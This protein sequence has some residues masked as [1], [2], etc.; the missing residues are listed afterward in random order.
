MI[1]YVGGEEGRG[2]GLLGHLITRAAIVPCFT[3]AVWAEVAAQAIT[4]HR[5]R[6]ARGP[7]NHA[8]GRAGAV[9]FSVVLRAAHRAWPIWNTIPVA[10]AICR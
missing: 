6:L 7:I 4:P 5:V 8:Y 10:L 1:L 3:T 9:L 2:S